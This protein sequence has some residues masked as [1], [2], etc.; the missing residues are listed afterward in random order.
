MYEQFTKPIVDYIIAL[1]LLLLL[2]PLILLVSILLAL[3][4]WGN[5]FFLSGKTGKKRQNISYHQ[6]QN[7]A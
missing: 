6:T 4:H 3:S 5:P 1:V 7:H 2:S